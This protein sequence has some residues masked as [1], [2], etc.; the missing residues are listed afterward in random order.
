MPQYMYIY[1]HH[2]HLYN[3]NVPSCHTS[4][5]TFSKFYS[6]LILY[7]TLPSLIGLVSTTWIN[8]KATLINNIHYNCHTTAVNFLTNHMG[9]ISRHIMPLVTN[10]LGGRYTHIHMHTDVCTETIWRDKVHVGLRLACSQFNKNKA[11]SQLFKIKFVS[12]VCIQLPVISCSIT[13]VKVNNKLCIFTCKRAWLQANIGIS[14]K[15]V[16]SWFCH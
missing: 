2:T 12:T 16:H 10:N 6:E 7:T 3:W 9:S 13:I 1:V 5:A 15:M 4:T 14:V 11:T 8:A